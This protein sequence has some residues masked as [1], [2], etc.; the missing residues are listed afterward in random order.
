MP[1]LPRAFVRRGSVAVRRS[2]ARRAVLG[3]VAALLAP[4]SVLAAPRLGETAGT[5]APPEVVRLAESGDARIDELPARPGGSSVVLAND[6]IRYQ[7]RLADGDRFALEA[8]TAPGGAEWIDPERPMPELRLNY[9]GLR[10]RSSTE[11]TLSNTGREAIARPDGSLELVVH[12]QASV[13]GLDVTRRFRIWPDVAAVE[14]ATSLVNRGSA[15]I[16]LLRLD[17]I[18]L[19]LAAASDGP[20]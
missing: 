15:P 9:A 11:A 14:R 3:L 6:R 13:L 20:W 10:G 2:L 16:S 19:D 4:A 7:L 18:N 17:S 5:A 8:L 12:F 1:L